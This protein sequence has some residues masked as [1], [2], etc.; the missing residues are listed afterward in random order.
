MKILF[1][2]D[3]PTIPTGFGVVAEYL[4]RELHKYGHEITV[5]G[6]NHFGEPYD[7]A[8][9]PYA[10][11]PCDRGDIP[12]IYGYSKAW[13]LANKV[14]PDLIFFLNDPWVIEKYLQYKPSDFPETTKFLCYYPIDAGPL[15]KRWA[16]ML[17]DKF[18][19]QVCYSTYAENI[20]I[21]ALGYRP[22]NLYQIY[23]GVDKTD[24]FPINQSIARSKL[25][26][27]LNSFIV[28]MVARNQPRKRFDLLCK[29]FGKFAQDKK[30]VKLYLHTA[31]DDVGFDIVDLAA[32]NGL[33]NKLIL[34]EELRPDY[35]VPKKMLNFIYNSFDVNAL[36]SLG[37]GFGLPVAESMAT[38]VPQLVSDHSCLKEL[39]EGSRGGMTVKNAAWI[40][41][42]AGINTVGG[43]SDVDDIAEKLQLFYDNKEM[44]LQMSENG[45][46]FITQDKFN[47][48]VIGKQFNQI[49]KTIFHIL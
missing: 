25:N 36:I 14:Q 8:V 32:Q 47:W 38:A 22:K 48:E 13:W 15:R 35:G 21:E 20:V 46:N 18:A 2:G 43:V 19:A 39:V 45:Y 4:L 27:P 12:S 11:Y 33:D 17:E 5:L 26:L 9:Y 37:D 28:G 49:I 7:Q 44:R 30:D 24:Y 41:N 16:K 34:T 29:G 42:P 40:M 6:I 31:L 1:V 23:H 3:S 10:I